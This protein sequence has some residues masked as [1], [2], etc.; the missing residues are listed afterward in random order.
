MDKVEDKENFM[1]YFKKFG[2]KYLFEYM[3]FISVK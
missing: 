2:E 1:V 3:I